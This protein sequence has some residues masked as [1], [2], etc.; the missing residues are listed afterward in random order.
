MCMG[1]KGHIYTEQGLN[2]TK[3][4]VEEAHPV[5]GANVGYL[6]HSVM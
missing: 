2:F 4:I 1:V 5:R 6:E 3:V